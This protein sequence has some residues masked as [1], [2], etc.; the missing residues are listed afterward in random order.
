VADDFWE[1]VQATVDG[2]DTYNYYQLL[3]VDRR[4]SAEEIRA[5]YFRIARVLHPDR[6]V[7]EPDPARQRSLVRAY[8]RLSEAYRVLIDDE[9]RR[10]YDAAVEQGNRRLRDAGAPKA[11]KLV[12]ARDPRSEQARQMLERGRGYLDKGERAKAKAQ[13][14]L[15]RQLEPGSPAIA[16]ALADLAAAERRGG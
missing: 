15:A 1:R 5:A 9:R 8:A 6:H 11:P 16:A 7:R 13:L 14:E 12:D 4:A 10:D 2:L 3:G